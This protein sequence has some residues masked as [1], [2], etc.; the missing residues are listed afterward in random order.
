MLDIKLAVD[1]FNVFVDAATVWRDYLADFR[2]AEENQ[3]DIRSML[4]GFLV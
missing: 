1:R 2:P 4:S 3:I